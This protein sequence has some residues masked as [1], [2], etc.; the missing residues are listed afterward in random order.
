M[1]YKLQQY[2]ANSLTQVLDS[3]A[4]GLRVNYVPV[5]SSAAIS[6]A[7]SNLNGTGTIKTVI[8]GTNNGTLINTITVKATGNV[9]KG[10][11]RLFIVSGVNKV[12]M[13]EIDIPATIQDAID[14]A[15]STVLKTNFMLSSGVAIAASTQNAEIFVVVA[16]G[17]TTTFP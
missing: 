13:A 10:M 14:T 12:L 3:S 9:T 11:V 2:T 6:T 7:N 4:L 8:T 5:T 1:L 17:L 15:F 16:E